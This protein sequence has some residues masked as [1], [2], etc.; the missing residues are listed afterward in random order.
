MTYMLSKEVCA[1]AKLF[2]LPKRLAV[3]RAALSTACALW[4]NVLLQS[5]LCSNGGR[6]DDDDDGDDDDDDHDDMPIGRCEL[7][8]SWEVN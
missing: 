3:S 8:P 5:S 7:E 1:F 2:V 6:P 4:N